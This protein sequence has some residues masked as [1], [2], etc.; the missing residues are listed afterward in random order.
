MQRYFFYIL[1]AA[2]FL[3]LL[4]SCTKETANDDVVIVPSEDTSESDIVTPTP[5]PTPTPKPYTKLEITEVMPSNGACLLDGYN[6]FSDWIELHNYGDESLDLSKFYLS[7]NNERLDKWQ[8][9]SKVLSPDEYIVIF[10]SGKESTETE[11]HAPF[12]LSKAGETLFLTHTDGILADTFS[13]ENAEKNKSYSEDGTG[14]YYFTPGFP[15]DD[16]GFLAYQQ[17]IGMPAGLCFTE[18]MNANSKYIGHDRTYSDWVELYN[19]SDK[20]IDLSNYYISDDDDNLTMCRLPSQSLAPHSYCTIYCDAQNKSF[21]SFVTGFSLGSEDDLYLVKDGAVVDFISLKEIP[22]EYSYGR[23]NS[24]FALFSSPSPA[25]ANGEGI[26]MRT[27]TPQTSV[28][29]GV[30]NDAE[31][32]SVELNGEGEIY[33]TLDGSEPTRYSHKYNSPLTISKTTVIRAIAYVDGKADS[34]IMTASYIY[35]ENHT[36]PVLSLST[37]EDNLFDPETG[38]YVEGNHTNYYQDWEKPANLALFENGSTVFSTDCGL[39]MFGSGSRADCEKKSLR[40]NF[41][42]KYGTSKLKS[43]VF[44]DGITGYKSLVMRAGEDAQYSIFRNELFTSLAKNSALLVQNNKYCILYIDGEYFGIFCLCERFSKTY[45]SQHY[46]INENLVSIAEA[47]TSSDTPMGK[48]M[49]YVQTHDMTS[50]ENYEYVK[51][52]LDIDSM[53]DWFIFQAYSH[54]RDLSGNIRYFHRADKDIVQYAFYDLDW[55]FYKRPDRYSILNDGS[56]Y[57]IIIH[58]LLKNAEFRAHF[59]KRNAYILNNV[60]TDKKVLSMIEKYENLIRPEIVR[61]RKRWKGTEEDIKTPESWERA[62]KRMKDY[63]TVSSIKEEM[64]QSLKNMI[65]LTDEEAAIIRG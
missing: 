54:N 27:L 49:K 32:F 19:N 38:I 10:A 36:L 5:S 12:K 30:Y 63:V 58:H 25:K 50:S 65:G 44:S 57:S 15:N 51:K 8:I 9:P 33:Y 6:E 45:Y 29:Q 22:Y 42:S 31:P 24:G 14:T 39:Q 47:P 43:D 53:S 16:A 48:L 46:D 64:I 23:A 28:P 20:A 55:A 62:V 1:T 13:Y 52:R 59:I 17:S 37:D 41:K 18:A 60:L 11:F 56:Q 61:E 3:F 2:L 21:K 34:R 35:N 7:D 4:A 26:R 40:V